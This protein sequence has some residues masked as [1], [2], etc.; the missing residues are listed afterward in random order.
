[1]KGPVLNKVESSGLH[2][3]YERETELRPKNIFISI[4][5]G[6]QKMAQLR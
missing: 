5:T 2:D 1:M 6:I 3:V 4:E